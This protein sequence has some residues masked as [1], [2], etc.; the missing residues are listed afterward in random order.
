MGI[1]HFFSRS[2]IIRRAETQNAARIGMV[3]RGAAVGVGVGVMG[4]VV[5]VLVGISEVGGVVMGVSSTRE[6]T[7]SSTLS[8]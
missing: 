5:G 6:N 8:I 1:F 7:T 3:E 2:L 4:M